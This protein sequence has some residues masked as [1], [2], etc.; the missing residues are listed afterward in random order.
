MTAQ[1]QCVVETLKQVFDAVDVTDPA[2]PVGRNVDKSICPECKV[3]GYEHDSDC[4]E[5]LSERNAPD[6]VTADF[7]VRD[8]SGDWWDST[9]DEDEAGWRCVH[10]GVHED[11][12]SQCGHASWCERG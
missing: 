7:A 9:P 2:H 5:G 10:C 4:F 11:D 6:I 3:S 12:V 1:E 8:E